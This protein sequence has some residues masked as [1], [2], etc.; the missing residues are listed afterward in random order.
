MR[1]ELQTN[2]LP[3]A[4]VDQAMAEVDPTLLELLPLEVCQRYQIIPL[5]RKG[6]ALVIGLYKNLTSLA[7]YDIQLLTGL[8]VVSVRLTESGGGEMPGLS[9]SSRSSPPAVRPAGRSLLR[10]RKPPVFSRT[11]VLREDSRC[12]GEAGAMSGLL[13]DQL[14]SLG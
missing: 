9:S 6:N 4:D 8:R 3:I 13:G 5:A 1:D 2:Q 14:G 11:P 10:R 12:R 7:A